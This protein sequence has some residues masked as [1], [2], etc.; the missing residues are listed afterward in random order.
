MSK[1]LAGVGQLSEDIPKDTTYSPD[2]PRPVGSHRIPHVL[3]ANA[4]QRTRVLNLERILQLSNFRETYNPDSEKAELS[5]SKQLSIMVISGGQAKDIVSVREQMSRLFDIAKALYDEVHYLMTDP[6]IA[7]VL[8]DEDR[9]HFNQ[10]REDLSIL[11]RELQQRG[12]IGCPELMKSAAADRMRAKLEAKLVP[13]LNSDIPKWAERLRFLHSDVLRST[14]PYKLL[15]EPE[16][17]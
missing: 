2:M 13:K 7:G 11:H 15:Q 14:E 6:D 8:K 5:L 1:I 4:K 17:V 10:L 9:P 16:A 3:A 12:A